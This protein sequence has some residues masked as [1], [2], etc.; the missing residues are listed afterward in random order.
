MDINEVGNTR[1][2]QEMSESLHGL[3][4]IT[5]TTFAELDIESI[6]D[7]RDAPGILI[8][9]VLSTLTM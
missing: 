7:I 8:D 1:R 2:T 3:T 9:N 5:A 6:E 4:N